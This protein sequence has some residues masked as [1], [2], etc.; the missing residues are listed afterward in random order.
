MRSDQ[1]DQNKTKVV[2]LP[3]PIEVRCALDFSISLSNK[4]CT[5]LLQ[6]TSSYK[7]Q[8]CH[9]FCCWYCCKCQCCRL[10]SHTKKMHKMNDVLQTPPWNTLVHKE[11][12][13][14]FPPPPPLKVS[15]FSFM[16]TVHM[17][18]NIT[19]TLSFLLC[20]LNFQCIGSSTQEQHSAFSHLPGKKRKNI[21]CFVSQ[22]LDILAK[23]K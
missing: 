6:P 20:N 15:H 5:N 16:C 23:N 2:L 18:E 1:R 7:H 12:K 19:H 3:F 17:W 10:G 4:I 9:F 22:T 8:W 14:A 13:V 21:H 11:E